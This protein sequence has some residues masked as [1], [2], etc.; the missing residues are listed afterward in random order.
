MKIYSISKDDTTIIK[1]FA[2]FCIVLHNFFHW[3]PPFTGENEF[4]FSSHRIFSF[5]N[6]IE[7]TPG[8][9]INILF[10]Y[11]GH[12]GV[13]LFIFISAYGLTLSML[14]RNSSWL[15][16][17]VERL[18]KIYPL[19]IMGIIIALATNIAIYHKNFD[20]LTWFEFAKKAL[21]IHTILPE[22]GL[23]EIGPWWF[24]GLIMQLYILFPFLYKFIKN[25]D[26]KAVG[27]ILVISY[28]WI[29]ISQYKFQDI[30][31]VQLLQ[32]APGHLAEF[33]FGIWFAFNKDK[34]LHWIWFVLALILFVLGNFF[35]PFFPF[36]FIS[37]TVIF[38]FCFPYIQAILSKLHRC[39]KPFFLYLGSISMVLFVINVLF[40]EPILKAFESYNSAGM[41]LAAGLTF[42]ITIIAIAF[43]AKFIYDLLIKAFSFIPTPSGK[44]IHIIEKFIII[45]IGLFYIYVISFYCSTRF[46]TT[47]NDL[48]LKEFNENSTFTNDSKYY[49]VASY[50]ITDNPKTLL[51]DITFS[52]S[53]NTGEIPDLILRISDKTLWKKFP[54]RV[55]ANNATYHYTYQ[56]NRPFYKSLK[57]KTLLLYFWTSNDTQ[58][59]YKNVKISVRER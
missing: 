38:L 47:Y 10:S 33:C 58:G 27:V 37:V 57:D 32:N 34:T 46:S 17:M 56:Y 26:F 20:I 3:L 23:S 40:R 39:I 2:I 25:H 5:F 50:T 30:E 19:I 51:L 1:G 29:F 12:Y 14:N 45:L 28:S 52:Y 49:N 36:T 21:F 13:Q 54:V 18:K 6:S 59:E 41:H 42:L 44:N 35:K 7:N 31:D 24:F 11:L 48:V 8:E 55:K 4:D 22:S 43:L 15:T 16:F 53:H 9:I